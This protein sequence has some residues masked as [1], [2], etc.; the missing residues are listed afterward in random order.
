MTSDFLSPLEVRLLPEVEGDSY[1]Q[2]INP[3]IYKS[4]LVGVI[5]V[6]SGF[7]TN[8]VSFAPLKNLG[9]RAATIH[10][11]LYSIP[12]FPRKLADQILEEALNVTVYDPD[13]A[14]NMYFAVRVFGGKH[15]KRREE[16]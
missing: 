16:K 1:W 11:Y 14:R 15:K 3:L 6:P 13:L 9:Q 4:D 12:E 5:I 10:D 8:F 7:V 2:L